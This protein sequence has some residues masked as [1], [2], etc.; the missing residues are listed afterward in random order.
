MIEDAP[1][2]LETLAPKEWSM[3]WVWGYEDILFEM[4]GEEWDEELLKGRMGRGK[5]TEL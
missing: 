1:N 3:W 4:R 2:P 5:T